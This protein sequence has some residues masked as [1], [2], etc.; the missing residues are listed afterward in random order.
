MDNV[1]GWPTRTS[2]G[3][4]EWLVR[5]EE[6]STSIHSKSFVVASLV[7]VRDSTLSMI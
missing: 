2:G 7:K 3:G 5:V 4:R 6:S 1:D